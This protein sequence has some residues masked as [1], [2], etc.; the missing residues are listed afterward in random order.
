MQREVQKR[1]DGIVSRLSFQDKDRILS[2]LVWDLF[3]DTDDSN[4]ETVSPDRDPDQVDFN[5]VVESLRLEFFPELEPEITDS[6][7]SHGEW[8][9]HGYWVDDDDISHWGGTWT[10]PAANRQDAL[11]QGQ[12]AI[13][14]ERIERWRW[15]VI[16]S[17]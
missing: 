13:R 10:G 3:G 5:V 7:L 2:N 8:T 9:I 12:D 4:H 11:R 16:R 6:D 1:I 15:T 14:D 17:S